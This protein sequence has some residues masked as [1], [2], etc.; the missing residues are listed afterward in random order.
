MY[1]ICTTKYL[2]LL[3]N[4]PHQHNQTESQQREVR[5][6]VTQQLNVPSIHPVTD[7]HLQHVVTSVILQYVNRVGPIITTV[8]IGSNNISI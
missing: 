7:P 1:N 6:H 2:L 8:M 3:L 4:Q 5:R